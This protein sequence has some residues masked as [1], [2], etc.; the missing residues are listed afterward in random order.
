MIIQDEWVNEDYTNLRPIHAGFPTQLFIYFNT[1][2]TELR[3]KETRLGAVV[4][5]VQ[6]NKTYCNYSEN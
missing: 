2:I 1:Q 3:E 6:S 4:H 5:Q